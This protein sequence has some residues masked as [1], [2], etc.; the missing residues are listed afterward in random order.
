VWDLK[1]YFNPFRD[2]NP[3]LQTLLLG[4]LGFPGFQ[5]AFLVQDWRLTGR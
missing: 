5:N 2:W 3:T 1:T 4:T